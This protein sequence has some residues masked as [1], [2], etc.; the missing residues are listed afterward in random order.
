MNNLDAALCYIQ[1]G[2]SIIPVGRNK[3]PVIAWE[4]YQRTIAD[5]NTV[6]SWFEKKAYNLAVVTGA[7]SGGLVVIDFDEV[8]FFDRWKSEIG[9]ILD[10]LVVQRS[11]RGF[12][13]FFRCPQPGHNQ[14]LAF[15]ADNGENTGRRVAVETRAEGGYILVEPSIHSSG[16]PYEVIQGNLTKIRHGLEKA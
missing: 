3:R 10:G 14:K 15:L 1:S 12:H 6:R 16:K 11:G 8:G 9:D 5:E 7:I 2:L 13:V 4:S